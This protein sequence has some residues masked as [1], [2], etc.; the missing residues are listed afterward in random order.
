MRAY[1]VRVDAAGV[2]DDFGSVGV[3]VGVG[4]YH[5]T[6]LSVSPMLAVVYTYVVVFFLAGSAVAWMEV[7]L[8]ALA[9]P[10]FVLKCYNYLW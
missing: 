9:L 8:M 1:L 4:V 5:G 6:M 2:V 10:A 3:R 7:L